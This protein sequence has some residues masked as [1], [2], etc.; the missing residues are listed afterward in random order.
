MHTCLFLL[1]FTSPFLH[2]SGAQ[3]TGLPT[4]VGVFT[5]PKTCS[6][7]NPRRLTPHQTNIKGVSKLTNFLIVN[8]KQQKQ[9]RSTWCLWPQ[10]LL[11]G[12][13]SPLKRLYC[14]SLILHGTKSL[15]HNHCG[16]VGI[17]IQLTAPAFFS[18][19][20]SHFTK[21]TSLSPCPCG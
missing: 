19:Q 3:G 9:I 17:L 11:Q 8:D 7:P 18:P 2:S 10:N 14:C 5:L 15:T 4:M 12:S 1:N 6:Q 13:T 20:N 16:G 21:I